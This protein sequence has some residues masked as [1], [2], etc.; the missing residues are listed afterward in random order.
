M[1]DGHCSDHVEL[2]RDHSRLYKVLSFFEP[3]LERQCRMHKRRADMLADIL[4]VL[5]RQF[6]LLVCRQLMFEL[7]EI[8]SAMLD[9]KLALIEQAQSP[10]DEHSRAKINS[11]AQKSIDQFNSYVDSLQNS[12]GKLPETF[13]ED[14]ERPALIAHFYMGRLFSKFMDF[15]IPTRLLKMKKSVDSYNFV[16]EYC[17]RN[18]RAV[19]KVKSEQELCEEMVSLLPAKMEKIRALADL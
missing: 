5:S 9:N 7:G 17:K 18:P 8:Y 1:L 4:K 15:D 6:Y 12:N 10:P 16:V 11:L 13:Q 2:V 14:D 19:A 3:S